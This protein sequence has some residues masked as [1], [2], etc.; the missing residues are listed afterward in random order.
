MK[1]LTSISFALV[2]VLAF[3]FTSVRP[4]SAAA[5]F[6]VSTATANKNGSVVVYLEYGATPFFANTATFTQGIGYPTFCSPSGVGLLKCTINGQIA[7]YHANQ[8]AYIV[9]NG[10]DDNKAFFIVPE[11]KEQERCDAPQSPRHR[12]CCEYNNDDSPD[13]HVC[14][15]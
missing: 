14:Y 9:M 7:K 15:D 3:L 4:A 13:R 10:S 8:T 2:V 6:V 1:K 5:G 11:L 12:G